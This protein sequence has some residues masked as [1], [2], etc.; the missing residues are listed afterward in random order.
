MIKLTEHFTLEE[1]TRSEIAV[2]NGID[3]SC[4]EELFSNILRLSNTLEIIR[5]GYASPLSVSSGY[6]CPI[7]NKLIGGSLTSAHLRAD[8]ADFTIKNKRVI[9]ICKYIPTVVKDFDQVIYEFGPLG[10]VHLGLS[11]NPR[12]QLLTAVLKD[13]KTVY[14]PG[15]IEAF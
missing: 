7:L 4:P 5:G 2:R 14:L 10:W 1:L 8:A 11:D 3:N 13:G 6:R 12:R 15:I 9:D